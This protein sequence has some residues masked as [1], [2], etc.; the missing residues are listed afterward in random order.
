MRH[1]I[2]GGMHDGAVHEIQREG[3]TAEVLRDAGR[4]DAAPAGGG[5]VGAGEEEEEDRGADVGVEFVFAGHPVR[6]GAVE[7]DVA[8]GVVAG[9][10]DGVGEEVEGEEEGEVAD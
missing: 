5:G 7:E 1:Q 8:W 9:A 2:P 4:E 6:D 10:V 3:D